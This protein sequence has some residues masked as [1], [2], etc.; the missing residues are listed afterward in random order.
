MENNKYA[1]VLIIGAKS[2]FDLLYYKIPDS[3]RDTVKVGS[4]V[5]LP[6]GEKNEPKRAIAFELTS[7]KPPFEVKPIY[8]VSEEE[9]VDPRTINFLTFISDSFL[10]PLHTLVNE[11]LESLEKTPLIKFVDCVSEEELGKIASTSTGKKQSIANY[12]LHLK[13]ARLDTLKKKFGAVS[14]KYLAEIKETGAIEISEVSLQKNTK[15]YS[16]IVDDTA[17]LQEEVLK[18]EKGLRNSALKIIRTFLDSNLKIIDEATLSYNVRN[19]KKTLAALAERNI[20]IQAIPSVQ[21]ASLERKTTRLLITGGSLLERTDRIIGTLLKRES[22]LS[23]LIVFPE[24][25]LMEKVKA[26]YKEAFKERC[27]ISNERDISNFINRASSG[28]K[29]ILATEKALFYNIRSLETIILEDSSS[30]YYKANP[31][32]PFD[33]RLITLRKSE[34]DKLQV[35][36]SAS[37]PDEDLYYLMRNNFFDKIETLN[38]SVKVKVIDMR[39]EFKNRNR[40]MISYYLK[41]RINEALKNGDNVALILN[42]KPYSTFVMCRECGYVMKCKNCGNTMYFDN[43][44]KVLYC[45]VCGYEEKPPD[46]CP[47]CKSPNISYFGGGIQKLLPEIAATFDNANVVKMVSNE[48]GSRIITNSA[49]FSSTI[50]VGTEFLMSHLQTDRIALFGFVSIDTF[51]EGYGHESSVNAYKIFQDA[52]NEIKN[53]EIIIQTYIPENYVVSA[54]QNL[55]TKKFLEQELTLREFLNY[56]PFFTLIAINCDAAQEQKVNEASKLIAQALNDKAIIL[57]PSRGK[58]PDTFEITIKVLKATAAEIKEAL[59]SASSRSKTDFNIR[60]YPKYTDFNSETQAQ[61]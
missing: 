26:K 16:L 34:L 51:V 15:F 47:R 19:S 11:H 43:E 31:F 29:I 37:C 9:P 20:I 35:I 59:K 7:Q 33:A 52:A 27:L 3:L 42:R 32:S 61:Q 28:G 48:H 12:I 24:I 40:N 23:T 44:R 25:A 13:H 56:P 50:F 14:T 41:R 4:I 54:M 1:G 55:Q 39:S 22:P 10:I 58:D 6:Y 18:L 2:P 60:V 8:K 46:V 53:K 21:G 38:T 49:E 45:P 57:G 5:E 17:K 36:F 30:K